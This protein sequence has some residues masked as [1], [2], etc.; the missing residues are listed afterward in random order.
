MVATLPR[1]IKLR[2]DQT[3]AQWHQWRCD[4]ALSKPPTIVARLGSGL[5]NY[6]I[7]V[8]ADERF[9]VRINGLH[10]AN[11]SLSR[12]T[13]WRVLHSAHG[14]GLAPC[15]RYLNPELGA[16]VY[17]YLPLD[18]ASGKSDSEESISDI[19]TLLQSIHQLPELHYK[20]NIRERIARY[21]KQLQ[22]QNQPLPQSIK[23]SRMDVLELLDE[24]E[25]EKD[26]Q[27]VCHNDLLTANR[28]YS[29]GRL[30]AI[31]WEYCAMGSP[32]FDLAVITVGDKLSSAHRGELVNAYLKRVATDLER[33]KLD[34]YC[35]IYQYLE[36][37]WYL[38]N[39]E[40]C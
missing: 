26:A 24:L 29:G 13:E 40:N 7:L 18:T 12:S 10:S 34:Q 30:W 31:D 8:E 37:L 27:V 15:P 39:P 19:A 16:L 9:V 20:L 4:P 2:L 35:H 3:L 22:H 38:A 32:W 6:S 25:Q 21:E 36:K 11:N 5:S 1:N 17:D 28:I 33:H 14:A 23:T